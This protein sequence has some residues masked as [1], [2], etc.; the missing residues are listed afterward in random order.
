MT[1]SQGSPRA[2][3]REFRERR[4]RDP[5]RGLPGVVLLAAALW[6]ASPAGALAQAPRGWER[7]VYGIEFRDEAGV[8]IDHPFLGGFNLPR[9][10]LADSDGDGDLDLFIQERSDRVMFFRNISDGGASRIP[11]GNRPVR[12]LAGRRMVPLRGRGSGR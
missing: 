8:L 2:D 5:G 4:A 12:G 7:V 3:G 11:L 1:P 6:A 10:Q 9:P